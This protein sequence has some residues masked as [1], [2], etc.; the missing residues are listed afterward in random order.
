M[1][2]LF[3]S[4]DLHFSI[5]FTSARVVNGHSTVIGRLRYVS[6]GRW[7]LLKAAGAHFGR[8]DSS[9]FD[10]EAFLSVIQHFDSLTAHC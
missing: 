2:S 3:L 1:S 8:N 6:M 5:G 4:S 10:I 9:D 7:A